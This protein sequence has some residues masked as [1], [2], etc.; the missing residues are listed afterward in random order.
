VCTDTFSHVVHDEN[1]DG[2]TALHLPQEAEE[3]GDV[4]AAVLVEPVQTH[5]GI[6]QKKF[7][8][9]AGE[10]GFEALLVGLEIETHDGSGDDVEIERRE[11]EATMLAE[12]DDALADAMQG[13]LG[14]VYEGGSLVVDG[15]ATEARSSGSHAECH[16]ESEP[17]LGAFG[18]SATKPDGLASP[19]IANEPLSAGHDRGQVVC[20][21]HGE[22]GAHG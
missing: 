1:R 7:G 10:R 5:E 12:G 17:A 2:V 16:I 21:D 9:E 8:L 22:L 4:G 19:Q 15:E 6:E 18:L 14:E 13:V 3:S 20:A 11:V